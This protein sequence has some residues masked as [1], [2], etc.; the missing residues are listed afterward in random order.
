MS[1]ILKREI[2]AERSIEIEGEGK[3]PGE[4]KREDVGVFKK[5]E[6][7]GMDEKGKKEGS[8]ERRL[9]ARKGF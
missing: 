3:E 6:A 2:R 4:S 1:S 9:V 8:G 7:I 5:N